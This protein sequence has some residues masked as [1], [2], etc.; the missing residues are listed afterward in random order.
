MDTEKRRATKDAHSE[1]L[2]RETAYPH[3]A[4]G[5]GGNSVCRGAL[6]IRP[7]LGRGPI[8]S[9]PK[10]LNIELLEKTNSTYL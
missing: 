1:G 7:P 9:L 2:H 8:A 3:A 10:Y 5:G 4:T 6:K